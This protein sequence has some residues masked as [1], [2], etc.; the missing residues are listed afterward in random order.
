M[1]FKKRL[2]YRLAAI[3]AAS[4]FGGTAT[5]AERQA[6]LLAVAPFSTPEARQH[7]HAWADYLD[8]PGEIT[9]SIG[10]KLMLIPPGEFPMGSPAGDPR[11]F[12]TEQPQHR[13]RI[14][15]RFVWPRPR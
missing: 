3:T 4:M 7:Q 11:G 10:M 12:P 8:V 2:L 14:S 15:S 9:N 13:V 6:P 1:H 5:A